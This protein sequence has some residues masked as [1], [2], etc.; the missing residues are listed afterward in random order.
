MAGQKNRPTGSRLAPEATLGFKIEKPVAE[1]PVSLP[2][3]SDSVL[4]GV[5][6]RI[7]GWR[8]VSSG[9]EGVVLKELV[10]GSRQKFPMASGTGAVLEERPEGSGSYY[11]STLG[12]FLRGVFEL[13]I[14]PAALSKGR[15]PSGPLGNI[16]MRV[17]HTRSKAYLFVVYNYPMESLYEC[18]HI[19]ATN[20][21]FKKR[22]GIVDESDNASR[23]VSR[24]SIPEYAKLF[25]LAVLSA[26]A[27]TAGTVLSMDELRKRLKRCRDVSCTDPAFDMGALAASLAFSAP[28]Q[29]DSGI[30]YYIVAKMGEEERD[31]TLMVNKK[32]ISVPAAFSARFKV[33]GVDC[34]LFGDS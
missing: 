17:L 26:Q 27:T 5:R 19:M 34:V 29:D 1:R 10:P 2:Q 4:A 18:P 23:T 25:D 13:E 31:Y 33:D 22:D 20:V 32:D 12:K 6:K 9:N 7:A 14:N 16:K 3:T 30:Y 28:F 24:I 21:D 15:G 8:V 11:Y